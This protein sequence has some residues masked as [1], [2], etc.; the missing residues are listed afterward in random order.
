MRGFLPQLLY[1]RPWFLKTFPTGKAQGSFP[2]QQ[3]SDRSECKS[4]CTIQYK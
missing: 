3:S 4:A 1:L 2:P